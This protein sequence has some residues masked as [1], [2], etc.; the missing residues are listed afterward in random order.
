[1]SELTERSINEVDNAPAPNNSGF[2]QGHSDSPRDPGRHIAA[3][4][5]H[6]ADIGLRSAN[7]GPIHINSA[8]SYPMRRG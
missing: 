6:A 3:L 5:R 8:M 1:M 7:K 4:R 2:R